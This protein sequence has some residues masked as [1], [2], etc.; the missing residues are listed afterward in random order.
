M[1]AK[2]IIEVDVRDDAF[3]RF[4]ADF[5]K[6]KADVKELPGEWGYVTE[7]VDEMLKP[8]QDAMG[9]M[10]D[11]ADA[12][13][14]VTDESAK[15]V[16][17]WKNLGQGVRDASKATHKMWTDMAGMA[18]QAAS[19]TSEFL[20]WTSIGGGLAGLLGL[21]GLFGLEH[22]I[23]GVAESRRSALGLGISSGEQQ[24]ANINLGRFA[25]VN[26]ALESIAN[27][28]QDF[29]Q[30]WA[31]QAL[32]IKD[33]QQKN[34]AE[35]FA[36]TLS[37]AQDLYKQGHRAAQDPVVQALAVMGISMDDLRRLG[38]MS[39]E[40]L[41]A[42][43]GHY[44]ADTKLGLTDKENRAWQEFVTQLERAGLTLKNDFIRWITPLA[45]PL[46]KLSE[47]L[48]YFLD[49]LFKDKVLG[50]WIDD[51][52]HGVHW[53]ADQLE[54]PGFR[55]GFLDFKD[56][57]LKFVDDF[58]SKAPA[59]IDN[60]VKVAS[61]LE[62]LLQVLGL[63]PGPTPTMDAGAAAAITAPGK[64][65]IKDAKIAAWLSQN[66]GITNQQG[67]GIAAN[68]DRESSLNPF[69]H[70]VDQHGRLHFGLGQWDQTNQVWSKE[71]MD[72]F[73]HTMTSVKDYKQA[74]QEQLLF[75]AHD[76]KGRESLFSDFQTTKTPG[77][78]A[79]FF[80]RRYEVAAGGG[81]GL[82]ATAAYR[83]G[84]ADALWAQKQVQVNINNNTGAQVQ[85][86]AGTLTN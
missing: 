67:L 38:N 77:E 73:H 39:K 21:G 12:A 23:G 68:L 44:R 32:G 49:K 36:E 78:A 24:S 69:N 61:G 59:F 50:K 2:S 56:H 74:M 79:D 8:L 29:G 76:F 3:K 45:G 6:Y 33:F 37:K 5:E 65:G 1:V 20:K 48:T 70:V 35:L 82:D 63:I 41:N 47:A 19:I 4:Q 30:M 26:S 27:A 80:S 52:A 86:P 17:L 60:V 7:A 28:R 85:V 10:E 64:I 34:P 43:L 31:F 42:Q 57:L 46:G 15:Q 16:K 25:N 53:L 9:A 83:K 18:K 75:L 81:K 72:M 84:Y 40:E 51:L 13:E 22:M 54:S 11:A 58:A 62:K 55:Q 71:Y 66:L 14:R